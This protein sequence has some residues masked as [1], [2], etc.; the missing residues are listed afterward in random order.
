MLATK[1]IAQQDAGVA[2]LVSE[3]EDAERWGPDAQLQ[4]QAEHRVELGELAAE[5]RRVESAADERLRRETKQLRER[6]AVAMQR[7]EKEKVILG[8]AL[9]AEEKATA[10]LMDQQNMLWA[11]LHE[12]GG[13]RAAA[14]H[15]KERQNMLKL[16]MEARDGLRAELAKRMAEKARALEKVGELTQRVEAEEARAESWRDV[17]ER[18]EIELVAMRE[19]EAQ[20]VS[21]IRRRAERESTFNKR[22]AELR[23]RT[24]KEQAELKRI[25]DHLEE[26]NSVL[27][28]RLVTMHATIHGMHER[29]EPVP[30][31]AEEQFDEFGY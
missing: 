20:L 28:G 22:L 3:I 2:A 13:I 5:L 24:T 27:R 18:R 12:K 17:A 8:E 10:D 31:A 6:Q 11:Q 21:D 16:Q 1:L 30:R 15:L 9:A 26:Q 29:G 14:E 23:A 25:A 19:R 7:E 4:I